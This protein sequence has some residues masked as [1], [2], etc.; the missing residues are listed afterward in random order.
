M[1]IRLNIPLKILCTIFILLFYT[2]AEAQ[3]IDF[4]RYGDYTI[5]VDNISIGDLKFDGPIVSGGGIYEVE[6]IDSYVLSIIGVKYLDVGVQISGDGELFLNGDPSFSG[7]PEKSIP[8]TLK[9]AYANHGR[10][11]I[12]DAMFISVASGNIGSARF[13]ILGRQQQPPGPPPTPTTEGFDQTLVE[14]TAYLYLYGEIDVGSVNAGSYTGTITIHV[15]Y[16]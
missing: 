2:Q 14:E 11:N 8:F 7:D 16:E 9:A 6:L 13:P 4:K 1:T 15:E 5:T 12:S 10:N 3:E